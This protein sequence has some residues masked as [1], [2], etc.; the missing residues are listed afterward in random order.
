MSLLTIQNLD[1]YFGGVQA[2]R[3]VEL[4]VSQNTIHA[5][6]GPNGAGKTTLFNVISGIH[7]PTG[8]A[9]AFDRK[10]IDQLRPDQITACGISR[11]FQNIRIFKS[12]TVLENIM[13]GRHCRCREGLAVSFFRWPFSRSPEEREVCRK[14]EELLRF[15]GLLDKGDFK[16]GNLPYGSQRKLE[17]ARALASDPLLLL[18]DEPAAGMDGHETEE[19]ADL[20]RHIRERGVT[21]LLIEHD[22]N[23][24]MNISDTVTVLNFGEKI[25]QGVPEQIQIEPVVIEAYLGIQ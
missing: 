7:K 1:K 23:L 10:R 13:V 8:G 2:L 11:T 16:A 15:V 24:V 22:M 19:L 6:I 25:A 18:L 21:V 14:A 3:A 4:S 9:I 17:I 12:L 5:L 20:I